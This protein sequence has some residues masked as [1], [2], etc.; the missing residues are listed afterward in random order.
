M[1]YREIQ[2]D[3]VYEQFFRAKLLMRAKRIKRQSRMKER[4]RECKRV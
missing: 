4:L 2:C 1:L 3:E